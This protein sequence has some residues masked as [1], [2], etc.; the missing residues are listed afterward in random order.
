MIPLHL[1]HGDPQLTSSFL[2]QTAQYYLLCSL[3]DRVY[4]PPIQI[5]E[6]LRIIGHQIPLPGVAETE[7]AFERK[8][9]PT[10]G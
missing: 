7:S 8:T 2:S 3:V 6:K 9:Q 1:Q 10:A 4:L 5:I